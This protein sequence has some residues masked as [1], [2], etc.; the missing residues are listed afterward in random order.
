MSQEFSA[1]ILKAGIDPYVD[2]PPEVTAAL[3]RTGYIPVRG[4]LDGRPFRS[5]LVSLGG[6][7]HRLFV[8]GEMRRAAGVDVGDT[9]EVVLDHDLEPRVRPVPLLLRRALDADPVAK[10]AWDALTP[11]RRTE[12]LSY[13]NSLKRPETVERIV[14]RVVGMLVGGR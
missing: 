5:G 7:R 14:A 8:N 9:V 2:V 12:I 13:L 1:V 6:G 11:S 3:G 10:A 4:V